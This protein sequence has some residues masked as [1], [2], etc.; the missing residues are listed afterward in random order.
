MEKI[1]VG[2][3][4]IKDK[5]TKRYASGKLNDCSKFEMPYNNKENVYN[6]TNGENLRN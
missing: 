1:I 5:V 2:N 3:I 6:R 4:N